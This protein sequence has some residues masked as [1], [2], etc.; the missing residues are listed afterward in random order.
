MMMMM[1]MITVIVLGD[2]ATR[3]LCESVTLK[4]GGEIGGPRATSGPRSL[5]TNPAK[6]LL[7]L[8]LLIIT[9]SYIFFVLNDLNY[10][11]S[12]IIYC[13]CCHTCYW[14]KNPYHEMQVF[15]VIVCQI[16]VATVER[17]K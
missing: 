5:V 15:Q 16:Q 2:T 17:L 1:M 4:L 10:R 13:F 11:Y 9:N 3:E 12:S 6:L 8:L 7:Y 14:L